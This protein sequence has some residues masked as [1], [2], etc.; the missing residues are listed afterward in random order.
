LVAH[1][2]LKKH[3]SVWDPFCS[4][5]SIAIIEIYLWEEKPQFVLYLTVS[6]QKSVFPYDI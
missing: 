3:I 6:S 1:G 2:Q 4:I 5:Y